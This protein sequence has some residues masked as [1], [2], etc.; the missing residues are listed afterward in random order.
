MQ[1]NLVF[2]FISQI[3]FYFCQVLLFTIDSLDA[4]LFKFVHNYKGATDI[5]GL[6]R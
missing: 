2:R 6:F 4:F 5:T 3:V 1:Y